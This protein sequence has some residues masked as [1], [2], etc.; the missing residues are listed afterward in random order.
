MISK[1]EKVE[2]SKHAEVKVKR[3]MKRPRDLELLEEAQRSRGAWRGQEV[4]S[5]EHE[6]QKRPKQDEVKRAR[7]A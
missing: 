1:H 3:C 7:G 4:T 6:E 5:S 2:R